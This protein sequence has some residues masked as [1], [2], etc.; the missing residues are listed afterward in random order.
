M[1]TITH[2]TLDDQVVTLP[3]EPKQMANPI[4]AW[5]AD[6]PMCVERVL[7]LT[8]DDVTSRMWEHIQA[9]HEEELNEL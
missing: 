8:L 3:L 4:K 2:V 1:T 9:V 5:E 7:G 6:C